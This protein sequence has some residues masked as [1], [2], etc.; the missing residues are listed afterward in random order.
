[1]STCYLCYGC[2]NHTIPN[3][4]KL[5]LLRLAVRCAGAGSV[6]LFRRHKQSSSRKLSARVVSRAGGRE[7]TTAEARRTWLEYGRVERP[8]RLVRARIAAPRYRDRRQFRT[9]VLREQRAS[10]AAAAETR[11]VVFIHVITAA[12][13]SADSTSHLL[14][15]C[16][17]TALGTALLL[18]YVGSMSYGP[19]GVPLRGACGRR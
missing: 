2:K 16:Y 12:C 8:T 14:C 9:H 7:P 1:M 17:H 5:S 10:A 6:H 15:E 13:V 11:C 19:G 3:S 18:S 4:K